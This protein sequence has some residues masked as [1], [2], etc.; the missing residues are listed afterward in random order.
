[1][2]G[3]CVLKSSEDARVVDGQ[4]SNWGDFTECSR[5]CGGGVKKRYRSCKNPR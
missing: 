2:N 3:N 4:W 5:S 1:M